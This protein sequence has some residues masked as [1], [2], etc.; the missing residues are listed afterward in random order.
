MEWLL[1]VLYIVMS[2]TSQFL[3]QCQRWTIRLLALIEHE[4]SEHAGVCEEIMKYK[5]NNIIIK[6]KF[7]FFWIVRRVVHEVLILAFCNVLM[8]L[9]LLNCICLRMFV[10]AEDNVTQPEPNFNAS[11]H[12]N[13]HGTHSNGGSGSNS[14]P[15]S[16]ESVQR[17]RRMCSFEIRIADLKRDNEILVGKLETLNSTLEKVLDGEGMY[18]EQL[19]VSKNKVSELQSE[20]ETLL[21]QKNAATRRVE[22]F[23]SKMNGSSTLMGA[24][25][26]VEVSQ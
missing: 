3:T 9:S 6:R 4:Q 13:S 21:K 14:S 20:M 25:A 17:R 11:T 26:D 23:M 10:V 15:H 12:L 5:G 19:A 24:N 22:Q 2:I 8:V 7:P 18:R 16:P 1:Y